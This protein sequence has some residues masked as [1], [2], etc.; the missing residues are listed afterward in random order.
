MGLPQPTTRQGEPVKVAFDNYVDI[1]WEEREMDA[2][3]NE[4]DMD[5]NIIDIPD[6]VHVPSACPG[7]LHIEPGDEA[8]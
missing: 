6:P 2:L 5:P 4:T 7:T 3:I 8:S 1:V